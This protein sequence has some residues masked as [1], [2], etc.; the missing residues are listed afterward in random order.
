[1]RMDPE[2]EG[3]RLV[4]RFRNEYD[5]TVTLQ[6]AAAWLAEAGGDMGVAASIALTAGQ[7]CPTDRI[8]MPCTEP[9]KACRMD[10]DEFVAGLVVDL[11]ETSEESRRRLF[12]SSAT[13]VRPAEFHSTFFASKSHVQELALLSEAQGQAIRNITKTCKPLTHRP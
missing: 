12:E 1:M 7:R 10:S 5:L 9:N 13:T 6:D 11:S 3:T 4:K 8:Q 2:A